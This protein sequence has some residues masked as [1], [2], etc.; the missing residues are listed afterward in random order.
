MRYKFAEVNDRGDT[1]DWEVKTTM[2]PGA[3]PGGI[4]QPDLQF[5]NAVILTHVRGFAKWIAML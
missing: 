5:S 2:P 1:T 3:K 4:Q